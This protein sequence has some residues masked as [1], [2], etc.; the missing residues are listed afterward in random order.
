MSP[1]TALPAIG[2]MIAFAAGH[3]PAMAPPPVNLSPGPEYA[4]R[5]RRFQGIPGIER[6]PRGRLWATWYA[7]GPGEG[8]EN[9]VVLVTSDDDGRTWSEP[10]LVVDPPGF[11]RAF[12]PCLWVDPSGAMW[13]TWAQGVGQFDGRSGVWA[14]RTRNPD[15]GRPEWSPPRRLS[16]GVMMNKPTVLGSG[17]WLFPAA[18]WWTV[19]PNLSRMNEE[20]KLGLAPDQMEGLIHD[21]GETNGA[22][23]L[24]TSDGGKTFRLI[25]GPRVPDAAFDEHML[26][27]RR[28][29]AWTVFV[30]TRYGIGES[31]STDGGKT[32]SEG[33]DT[34]IHHANARFFI[35]RLR[36]GNLLLV[37]HDSPKGL[38]RSHLK[39]EISRDHGATW[40]GGLLLDE[41][42]NVSYPDGVESP[43]GKIYIVYDRE[44]QHDQE[45]LFAT[46]REQDV[47]AGACRSQDCRLKQAINRAGEGNSND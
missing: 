16:H 17:D 24:A 33:R 15:S 7:G 22:N 42:S 20:Y 37:R 41:R 27:E 23:L 2:V 34:G 13:L 21:L 36:S 12:D 35:R 14:I 19:K 46:F 40:T 39:A 3:D 4:A 38:E 9:Y 43:D 5:T 31:T 28:V 1:R 30:R 47:L 25:R 8:P 11:V 10:R 45:I 44:R 26:V 18:M 6:A 32:W 29:G